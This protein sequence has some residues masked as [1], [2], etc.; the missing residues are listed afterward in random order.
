M[1]SFRQNAIWWGTR[2]RAP[3]GSAP[4]ETADNRAEGALC[5]LRGS[6]QPSGGARAAQSRQGALVLEPTAT[7]PEVSTDLVAHERHCREAPAAPACP[8]PMAGATLP[9]QPPEV[10][11]V[12][13]N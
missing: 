6:D 7:K 10:G 5:L 11:A 4:S 1:P 2:S 13:V 3:T 8:A 9:R 12:C